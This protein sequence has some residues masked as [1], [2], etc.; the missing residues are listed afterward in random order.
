M[1]SE[2]LRT[3]SAIF[4]V[5]LKWKARLP[6][7]YSYFANKEDPLGNSLATFSNLQIRERA[8]GRPFCANGQIELL[9]C[10]TASSINGRIF[11]FSSA[12]EACVLV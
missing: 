2:R 10:G 5:P 4:Y 3:K 11:H 12:H 8:E 1:S 6:R 7:V 9:F